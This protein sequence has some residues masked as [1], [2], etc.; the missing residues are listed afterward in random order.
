MTTDALWRSTNE[1][2]FGFP[3]APRSSQAAG[4][5][6]FAALAAPPV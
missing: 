6:R 5:N 4:A 3:R 2:S 1:L